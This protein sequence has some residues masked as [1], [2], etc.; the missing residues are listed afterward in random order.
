MDADDS[1]DYGL[2][3]AL[4]T[5]LLTRSK[6]MSDD[7]TTISGVYRIFCTATGKV[8]IGST[9]NVTKRWHDHQRD[10]LRGRHHSRHL[11]R[12]WEKHGPDVFTFEV[13]E[14]IAD[15]TDLISAEQRWI[16]QTHSFD[17]ACGYNISPTAGSCLGCKH[18][19]ETRAKVS[20][21]GKGRKCPPF[22]SEHR[23]K[24]SAA[25]KG[26]APPLATLAAA[27]AANVG[28]VK[29]PEECAKISAAHIG[30]KPSSETRAKLSAAHKGRKLSPEH[31]AKLSAVKIG[32]RHTIESRAKISAAHKGR[33]FSPE[34]RAKIAAANRRRFVTKPSNHQLSFWSDD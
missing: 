28:R 9:A 6:A 32:K 4:D 34:H 23:A 16:D 19:P 15:K 22:S 11:Q 5:T 31:R 27:W 12:A 17:P 1:K 33:E 2:A 8:Y 30:K 29:T 25:K 24:M 13:L 3:V 14:I 10:L 20:A 18:T 26:K 7:N 21:A